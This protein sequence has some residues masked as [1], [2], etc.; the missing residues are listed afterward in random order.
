[1]FNVYRD[2]A[3][4]RALQQHWDQADEEQRNAMLRALHQLDRQLQNEPGQQG[5]SRN[6]STRVVF[7]APLALHFDVEEAKQLVRV[8]R[9]WAFGPPAGQRDQAA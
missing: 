2:Q 1:M 9:V 5:E 3:A 8:L 4:V 7:E 6:G